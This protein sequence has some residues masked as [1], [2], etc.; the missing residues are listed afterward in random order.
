MYSSG[1]KRVEE[2]NSRMT[3]EESTTVSN[4][5]NLKFEA[6]VLQCLQTTNLLYL[7]FKMS[8]TVSQ[9]TVCFSHSSRFIIEK[10]SLG[11]L[12]HITIN[13]HALHI[14]ETHFWLIL[15]PTLG[16]E[17][18]KHMPQKQTCHMNQCVLINLVFYFWYVGM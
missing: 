17:R 5:Q 10:L 8:S 14:T 11:A 1:K 2:Y 16:F 6:V 12:K 13:T 4:R 15:C 7:R 18:S 9:K 3:S